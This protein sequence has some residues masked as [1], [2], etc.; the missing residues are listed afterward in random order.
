MKEVK[1]IQHGHQKW[2]FYDITSFGV[3]ALNLWQYENKKISKIEINE[4]FFPL[5][6]KHEKELKKLGRDEFY[7]AYFDAIR[8][9]QLYP[10]EEIYDK[11]TKKYVTHSIEHFAL[12]PLGLAGDFVIMAKKNYNLGGELLVDIQ[13]VSI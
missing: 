3:I 11:Q 10:W 9:I 6:K 1:T 12:I 5:I 4:K 2:K 8:S 7:R 13:P